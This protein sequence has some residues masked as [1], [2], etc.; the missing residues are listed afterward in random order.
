M[1]DHIIA[2]VSVRAK[3]LR[4]NER[5]FL[6]VSGRRETLMSRMLTSVGVSRPWK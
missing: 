4:S 5:N 3:S 2:A 1:R 6:M